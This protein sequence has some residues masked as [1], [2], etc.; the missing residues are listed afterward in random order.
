[1]DAVLIHYV[2]RGDGVLTG[3]DGSTAR[4]GPGTL[5]FVP[6]GLDHEMAERG[7]ETELVLWKRAAS[8]LGDGMMNFA[9]S[10]ASIDTPIVTACGTISADC[11]GVRVF[12]GLREPIAEDLSADSSVRA[13]FERMLE[14]LQEPKFGTKPLTEALMKQCLTLATRRQ[15]ERSDASF[16]PLIGFNDPRLTRA[17]LT[18]MENPAR[19]HSL[20]ELAEVS[21]MS[22]SLFAERFT[23]AFDRPP[24]D[25]LRHL[26]LHRAAD[27]LRSTSLPV[28]V[29]ASTVGY[30]SRSYF[31]RAFRAAYGS[32]PKAFRSA[33]R[34]EQ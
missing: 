33:A 20:D 32:D 7:D 27:L 10:G 31:S 16:L 13:A 24:M 22:R 34:Q 23:Q 17:L 4:F 18:M 19:D 29:I 21:G 15:V 8:P 2:L 6:Q 1:M 12:Q 9:A 14:E 5:I 3:S 26:R 30:T 11:E 28:Q 25:M